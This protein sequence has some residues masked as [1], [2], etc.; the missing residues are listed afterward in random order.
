MIK[1]CKYIIKYKDVINVNK[2]L[3]AFLNNVLLLNISNIYKSRG[4]TMMESYTTI[5]HSQ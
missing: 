2:S 1:Y 5:A 4:S 3:C